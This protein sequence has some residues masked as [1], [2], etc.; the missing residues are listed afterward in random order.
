MHRLSVD[1]TVAAAPATVRAGDTLR[2]VARLR[3]PS[4]QPVV[5]EFDSSCPVRFYVRGA[6]HR[7]VEP[8]GGTW[9]CEPG[10][11][12]V[13]LAPGEEREYT[14]AWP[15]RGVAPDTLTVYSVLEE[16]HLVQ[17]DDRSF[18]AGHRSN[19]VTVVR[20]P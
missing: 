2:L 17:G 8:E 18:R 5:M 15:V 9:R 7:V 3:N 20:A 13:S 16:H 19:E 6:D 10:A 1:F 14:H 12:R 4:G 11:T